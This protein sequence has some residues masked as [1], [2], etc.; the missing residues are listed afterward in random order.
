VLSF[1]YSPRRPDQRDPAALVLRDAFVELL[2]PAPRTVALADVTA[3]SSTL[4]PLVGGLDFGAGVKIVY[5]GSIADGG[6]AFARLA[7]RAMANV[8]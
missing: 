7:R 6:A 4:S 8:S 2:G 1:L 3:I 5:P